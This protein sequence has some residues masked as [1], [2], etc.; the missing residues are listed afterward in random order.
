MYL[1]DTNV[2]SELRRAPSGR[3]SANV[4][5]WAGVQSVETLFLSVI[6]L[7]EIER[8][9][10][11]AN[12]RDPTQ[13]EILRRWFGEYLIPAFAGRILPIDDA[14]AKRAAHLHSPDPAPLADSLIAATALVHGLTVVT[15][16]TVDFQFSGL[17]V[18]D[19]WA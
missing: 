10:L 17:T 6:S 8:G 7:F 14:I 16:N 3:A 9:I 1:L 15:R 11:Q 5:A 18:F 4:V 19:P 13:G 12:R 2:I